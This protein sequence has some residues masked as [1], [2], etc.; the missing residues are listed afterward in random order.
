MSEIVLEPARSF[1]PWWTLAIPWLPAVGVQGVEDE[2]SLQAV[3]ELGCDYAA[4]LSHSASASR[5]VDGAVRPRPTA[6]RIRL[7]AAND[8]TVM[9]GPLHQTANDAASATAPMG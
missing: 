4:R 2:A 6:Q 8:P 9:F 5:R 3:T 7:R 1:A